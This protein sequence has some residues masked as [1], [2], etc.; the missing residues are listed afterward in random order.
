MCHTELVRAQL[1]GTKYTDTGLDLGW[2]GVGWV[3]TQ[4]IY[5]KSIL[6]HEVANGQ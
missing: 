3:V 1:P 6:S 4:W 5:F 2:G